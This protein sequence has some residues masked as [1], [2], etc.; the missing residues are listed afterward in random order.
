MYRNVYHNYYVIEFLFLK[1]T[2]LAN[3]PIWDGRNSFQ[4][5]VSK[6]IVSN[7]KINLCQ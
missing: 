6:Q 7:K 1:G 3:K 2:I 4:K 5:I